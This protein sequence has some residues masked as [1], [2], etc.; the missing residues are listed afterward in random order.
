MNLELW[1]SELEGDFDREF[2]LQGILQGFELLPKDSAVIP[3][4]M[5]NYSS[6]VKAS[7]RDKVEKAILE[8]L[9]AGNYV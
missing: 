9:A 5:D 6:A 2:L 8:E 1:N 4:E 7:S 3:A